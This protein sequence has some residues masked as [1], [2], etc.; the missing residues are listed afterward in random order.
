MQYKTVSCLY[1]EEED[2]WR[3]RIKCESEKERKESKG[4]SRIFKGGG[5]VTTG[6]TWARFVESLPLCLR[7]KMFPRFVLCG[8]GSPHT[9]DL[10]RSV[11]GG[12]TPHRRFISFCVGYDHPTQTKIFYHIFVLFFSHFFQNSSVD[13]NK[14]H[15]YYFIR[16]TIYCIL[17]ILFLPEF[18][19]GY[20]IDLSLKLTLRTR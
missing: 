14:I 9:D 10:F 1:R 12:V 4:R 18:T 19:S 17:H 5:Y 7:R 13:E 16:L 15:I 8:V 2:K 20:H 11:W 3:S 6:A